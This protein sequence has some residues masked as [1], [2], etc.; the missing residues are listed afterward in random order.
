MNSY[1][2]ANWYWLVGGDQS[3][4]WSSAAAAYVPA[5]D[6]TYEAWLGAGNLPTRIA[7]EAEL[8]EVLAAQYPAGWPRLALQADAQA[9]LDKADITLL[10]CL[11]NGVSVPA[12]WAAYRKALRAIVNGS[13]STSTSLPATPAY[14]AG[15]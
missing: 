13:D 8:Q 7:S 10:R 12:E 5:D 1:N 3:R 2:P 11:E 15:T 4:V 9:S 14:P 6:A